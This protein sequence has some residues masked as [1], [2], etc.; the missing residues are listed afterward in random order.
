MEVPAVRPY[1]PCL[2]RSNT[3][4]ISIET[5][6]NKNEAAAD[7][8]LRFDSAENTKK[9]KVTSQIPLEWSVRSNGLNL[10]SVS[11]LLDVGA[12]FPCSL[13]RGEQNTIAKTDRVTKLLSLM[14]ASKHPLES[15][16]PELNQG[17]FLRRRSSTMGIALPSSS[18]RCEDETGYTLF[19]GHL[20][21]VFDAEDGDLV[22]E[23]A[24][25]RARSRMARLRLCQRTVASEHTIEAFEKPLSSVAT[26]NHINNISYMGKNDDCELLPAPVKSSKGG[27]ATNPFLEKMRG[28]RH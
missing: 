16:K 14:D 2:A 19:G 21:N 28:C 13:R 6:S 4:S 12:E 22:L 23:R 15:K 17:P 20:Y 26:S 24:R 8:S 7:S 9:T 18:G 1:R 5:E 25:A 11:S 10:T 27:S 3:E